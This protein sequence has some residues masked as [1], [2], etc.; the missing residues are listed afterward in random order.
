M[1]NKTILI[2]GANRGLGLM[3]A[4]TFIKKNYSTILCSKNFKNFNK[5]IKKYKNLDTSKIHYINSDISRYKDILKI[6]NY[7][8]N[9]IQKIDVLINNAALIGPIGEF[10]KNNHK[11]LVKTIETNLYGSINM[12]K[13]ILP[14]LKKSKKGKIIQ[15]SGGGA[16][17]PFPHFSAY[18]ISKVA[19]VRF[20][21]TI[22]IELKK[23]NIDANCVAPGNLKTNIQRNV[24]KAGKKA[25]GN[26]YYKKINKM[27]NNKKDDFSKPIK[28]IEFLIS[29]KSD[30]ITGKLISAVWDNWKIFKKY[31]KKLKD[32]D[33]FTLRRI[34]GRERNFKIGDK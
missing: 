15:I 7:L 2:T 14:F 5:E 27:M 34:I 6:K 12:I 10:E 28:L 18:A 31:K 13:I 33:I 1:V 3:L 29:D 9:K 24:I 23:Y 21:E 22:S 26:E 17:G 20:V 19:I 32:N 8:K 16:S 25:V 30:G 4:I 11:D